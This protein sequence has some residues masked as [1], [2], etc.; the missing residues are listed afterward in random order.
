MTAAFL[1][2]HFRAIYGSFVSVLDMNDNPPKFEQTSYSCGL[3]VNANRDQ[4][5]T[6]VKASDPD[7][8]DQ[9]NLRYTIVAGNEQQTFSM[10]PETGIITLTNLANFGNENTMILNVSVSDGVYTNF[11]R[12][13]VELLPANLHPPKFDKFIVDVQVPENQPPDFPVTVVKATDDDFGEFGAISYSIHSDLLSETF[14][15]DKVTGKL[16]TKVRLDR[17]KQKLYE[18]PVMAT[19]GGGRAG[20]LTVR[21]KVADENDNAPYFL[22]REYKTSIH[23]NH[24]VNVP[25]MRVKA[26]DADE[27]ASAQIRYQIYEKKSSEVID[28]FQIDAETGDLSLKKDASS[29]SKP[30]ISRN[31]HALIERFQ[32]AMCSSVSSGLPIKVHKKD[33]RMFQSIF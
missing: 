21:I 1:L 18:V 22:L 23:F 6:I 7:D 20:F 17:E 25:F 24:S 32:L 19:D 16:S 28:V 12:L 26:K 13:K 11:A 9:N 29:W 5:V 8:V 30:Q 14:K 27:G 10:N 3:L 4:F 31:S 33:P 15:I 2:A